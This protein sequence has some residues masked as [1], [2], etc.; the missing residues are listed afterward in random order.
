VPFRHSL[1]PASMWARW[2]LAMPNWW[3]FEISHG[4]HHLRRLS[5]FSI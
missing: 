3:P 1:E 5:S 4:Q 2:H